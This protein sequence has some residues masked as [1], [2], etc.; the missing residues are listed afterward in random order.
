VPSSSAKIA[1][2]PRAR[3]HANAYAASVQLTSV[4]AI[5]SALISS[6]LNRYREKSNVV[7]A[8]P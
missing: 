8:S 5:V 2:R 7:S 1:S 4:P 6:E 3:R